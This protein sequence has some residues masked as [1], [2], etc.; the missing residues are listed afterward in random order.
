MRECS[1]ESR[2]CLQSMTRQGSPK[3]QAKQRQ[4]QNPAGKGR[5][6]G[7]L[8]IMRQGQGQ[9]KGRAGQKAK[10]KHAKTRSIKT[11]HPH[12]SQLLQ[13]NVTNRRERHIGS[14]APAGPWT[15]RRMRRGEP[16]GLTW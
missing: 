11:P 4:C 13:T 15:D 5:A 1:S 3:A 10:E 16:D 2:A 6:A 14:L 7:Q 12:P 9:G 8:G